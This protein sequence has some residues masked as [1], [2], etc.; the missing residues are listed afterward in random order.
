M[1]S[2]ANLEVITFIANPGAPTVTPQGATGAASYSYKIVGVD[3]KGAVTAAS[4]AGSTATGNA[5]L[6]SSNFN[7]VS[8]SAVTAASSYQV[9]R[10]AGGATQGL[11]GTAT[12][13]SF[14]DTGFIANG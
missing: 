8:W 14:D 6:N 9:W 2:F 3:S 11:V 4:T 13:T 7:R 12:G 10:T 1:G 5:T